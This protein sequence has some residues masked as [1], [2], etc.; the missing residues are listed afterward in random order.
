MK[1][2]VTLAIP[3]L[4]LL[5]ACTPTSS[6]ATPSYGTVDPAVEAVLSRSATPSTR[7]AG[8][9]YRDSGLRR[10]TDQFTGRTVCEQSVTKLVGRDNLKITARL[11]ERGIYTFSLTHH[12]V[13]TVVH[14]PFDDYGLLLRF[15]DGR[16]G[17]YMIADYD[18]GG[19]AE[20]YLFE[21]QI[22]T[23]IVDKAFYARLLG[24]TGS[25]SY[26][27]VDR[28]VARQDS[29]DGVITPQHIAPL[30]PF[31]ARCL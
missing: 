14:P 28:D 11:D 25:L 15:P 5:G 18:F 30:R 4:I 24:V 3:F 21:Y 19:D 29:L 20:E 22:H 17:G 8:S 6:T 27:L 13:N 23:A 31:F 2:L 12:R 7:T 10:H 9:G 26:R 1:R 16:V